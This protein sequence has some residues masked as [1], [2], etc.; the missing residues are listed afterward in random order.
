MAKPRAYIAKLALG[1]KPFPDVT[2]EGLQAARQIRRDGAFAFA[3]RFEDAS[4]ADKPG[5]MESAKRHN[6]LWNARVGSAERLPWLRPHGELDRAELA[7]LEAF[8]PIADARRSILATARDARAIVAKRHA[9]EARG[10]PTVALAAYHAATA[11][12]L[13]ATTFQAVRTAIET[14]APSA[15]ANP[16]LA[17]V[18]NLLSAY[19]A[20]AERT[21]DNGNARAELLL[22]L[23]KA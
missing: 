19:L 3:A 21:D 4:P 12:E 23:A 14:L 1:D 22:A 2:D 6:A 8:A 16:V 7:A 20:I 11:G 13:D 9:R 10:L 15:V 18:V 5:M 17:H